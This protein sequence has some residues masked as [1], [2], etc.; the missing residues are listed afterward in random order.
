MMLLLVPVATCRQCSRCPAMML[1]LVSVA[2]CRQCSRC[3]AQKPGS[4]LQQVLRVTVTDW[5]SVAVMA[6]LSCKSLA[7]L[8]RYSFVSIEVTV[9]CEAHQGSKL[10][11][12]AELDR[13]T[14]AGTGLVYQISAE[15]SFYTAGGKAGVDNTQQ[16][17]SGCQECGS[18]A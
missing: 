4:S 6:D 17:C 5:L 12:A 16:C 14:C 15:A 11:K 10:C 13:S 18:C 8:D 2:T 1:L 3:Q 7:M 9:F